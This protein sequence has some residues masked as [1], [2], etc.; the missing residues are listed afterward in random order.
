MS[1]ARNRHRRRQQAARRYRIDSRRNQRRPFA[2][3]PV[4]A[5]PHADR[6]A[7][8]TDQVSGTTDDPEVV[9]PT[10]TESA[11]TPPPQQEGEVKGLDRRR[12]FGSVFRSAWL[13]WVIAAL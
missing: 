2:S 13:A 7:V 1:D 6:G 4:D 3:S 11:A 12:G 8:V 10:G 9:E 5:E